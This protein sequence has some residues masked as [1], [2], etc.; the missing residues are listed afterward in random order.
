MAAE[1]RSFRRAD[2]EQVTALVNAHVQAV[3]PGVSVPQNAV[4]AQLERD[5]SEFIVDPWVAE[6]LM[7]VAE[8]RGRIV[9]AA[10]LHCYAD[11]ERV[12]ESYRNSG[13][14]HWLLC[15]RD[16]P[17]WPDA[18]AAGTALMQRCVQQL[19]D[20]DVRVMHASGELPAPVIYGVSDSW[21]HVIDLYEEGGFAHSGRVE[22][23]FVAAIGSVPRPA[24]A[25]IDGLRVR[26]DFGINGT[27]FSAV[28]GDRS[29]GFVEV[30]SDLT[31][32]GTRARFAGWAD[33]GNLDIDDELQRRGLATWLLGHAAEWL[34][35]GHVDRLLAYA[36]PEEEAKIA[37]LH[38]CGFT[39]LARTR[40]GWT[41]PQ[42]QERP[43]QS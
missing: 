41:R 23:I 1:I 31:R 39:E 35:V 43:R 26:R 25:P 20:W 11:D 21:P 6:R 33:V 8:E 38:A 22:I 42:E 30:A 15:W 19:A 16:A 13:S 34:N 17:Y 4:L 37:F 12:D 2:G 29:V 9:A 24:T 40:R 28:L 32:G 7:L 27:R 36:W 18:S 3:L 14:I 10:L 5:P